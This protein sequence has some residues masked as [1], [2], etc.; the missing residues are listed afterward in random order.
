MFQYIGTYV[1]NSNKD[2]SGKPKWTAQEE[3]TMQD[4][5]VKGSFNF[6]RVNKFYKDNV[7][8]NIFK[9]TAYNPT[10]ATVQFTIENDGVGLYRIALDIRYSGNRNSFYANDLVFQGKPMWIEYEIKD[11]GDT[12]ADIA[13]QIVKNAQKYN[14]VFDNKIFSISAAGNIV[15]ITAIDEYE[16]FLKADIEKLQVDPSVCSCADT[17]TCRYVPIK[18]ATLADDPENDGENTITQGKEGFGTFTHISKDLRLPTM[19]AR[20]FAGINQEELPVPG[21]LYNQYT[22]NYCKNRDILGSDAVGMP[23]KSVTTHVFFV[24]QDISDEFEAALA[25]IGTI[26]EVKG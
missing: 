3:D 9:R 1:V 12:A 5:P 26:E 8:G 2:I 16:R 23:V 19:E 18:K 13:A 17:C 6:K 22:L 21:A 24:R 25:N 7:Y 11:N 14:K 10:M 20:R 4:P 15:T